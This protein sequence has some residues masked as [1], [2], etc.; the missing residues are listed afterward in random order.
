[1]Q[2][3]NDRIYKDC[4]RRCKWFPFLLFINAVQ[5]GGFCKCLQ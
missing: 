2:N 3:D 4:V 5:N 1:M